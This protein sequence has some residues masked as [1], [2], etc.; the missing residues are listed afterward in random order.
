M[1]EDVGAVV[2]LLQFVFQFD[3]HRPVAPAL[4]VGNLLQRDALPLSIA[5]GI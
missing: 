3:R 5:P 1:G 2:L 4:N